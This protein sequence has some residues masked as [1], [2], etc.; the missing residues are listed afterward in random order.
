[1]PRPSCRDDGFRIS[2]LQLPDDVVTGELT[3]ARSLA[4]CQTTTYRWSLT[5]DLAR[6]AVAGIGAIGLYR[7]KLGELEEDVAV[8]VIRSSGLSISSLSWIGGFTGCDGA[9]QVDSIFDAT[10]AVRFA[11]AVGANTVS[12]VGGSVGSHISKHARRL[13]VE[14]LRTVCE[15]AAEL[16]VRLAL[17]PSAG[18]QPRRRAVMGNLDETL[19][20]LHAVERPNL[21]LMLDV[22]ELCREPNPSVKIPELAPHVHVVRISDRRGR[23]GGMRTAGDCHASLTAAVDGLCEAGFDGPFE[24]DSWSEV[25]RSASEYASL[26]VSIRSRFESFGLGFP[27]DDGATGSGEP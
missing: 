13:L 8:D 23:I 18:A 24:F 5:E 19:D 10:E 9:R 12:V 22:V 7:P 3:A 26:L 1:V 4:V 14:S 25:E 2:G 21:G 17:H 15:F 20:V 27:A 6:Y 11:A 16:D